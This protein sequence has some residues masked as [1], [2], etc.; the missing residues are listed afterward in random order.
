MTKKEKIL[1]DKES[2]YTIIKASI[3][4]EDTVS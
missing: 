4:Q 3:H 2:H 1:K